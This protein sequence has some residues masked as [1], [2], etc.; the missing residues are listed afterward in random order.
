[1]IIGKQFNASDLGYVTRA[2][3]FNTMA[4]GTINSALAGVAFPMLSKVQNDNNILLNFYSKYIKISAFIVAPIMFFLCGIAKPLIIF[5][6]TD[7]WSPSIILMQIL[8]IS[9]VWDGIIQINLNLLYVKG[10]SDLV[11]KLEIIKKSIAFSIVLISVLIGNLTVFCIGMTVYS[12]IAFYLN[13]IY[14]KRILNFGFKKQFFQILPYLTFSTIILIESLFFSWIISTPLLSLCISILV[15]IP[16]Y[17]GLCYISK[18]YAL[19]ECVRTIAPKLGKFG[20][21]LQS[22]FEKNNISSH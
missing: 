15:C 22:L 10:R 6:L 13:T 1:M 4:V 5:L 20:V 7:K 3:G 11:L 18:Q 8:S 2:Q 9:Y 21:Q 12:C 17:L 16:T 19:F 14:T